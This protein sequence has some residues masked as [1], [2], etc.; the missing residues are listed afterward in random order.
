M[1][2]IDDRRR[3]EDVPTELFSSFSDSSSPVSHTTKLTHGVLQNLKMLSVMS[4]AEPVDDAPGDQFAEDHE[5][6]SQE[7]WRLNQLMS[8]QEDQIF[9][10]SAALSQCRKHHRSNGTLEELT[11]HRVLILSRERRRAYQDVIM[12]MSSQGMDNTVRHSGLMKHAPA[13]CFMTIHWLRIYLNRNYSLKNVEKDASYA[14]LA[15]FKSGEKVFASRVTSVIDT[16]ALRGRTVLFPDPV[17]LDNLPYDFRITVK[18]YAMRI[19]NRSKRSIFSNG[20]NIVRLLHSLRNKK[21]NAIEWKMENTDDFRVCGVL[22]LTREV[23]GMGK[24]YLDNVEYPLDGTTDIRTTI[25]LNN[26]T[27]QPEASENEVF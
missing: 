8:T 14:F 27:H 4:T 13:A 20:C 12:Q 3:V 25:M 24:Y 23:C 17:R 11:A 26:A 21:T 2:R 22:H 10:S 1:M 18:V 9:Q 16:G 5:E 19:Q 7:L 6:R 15:I